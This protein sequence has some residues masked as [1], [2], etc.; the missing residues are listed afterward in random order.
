VIEIVTTEDGSNTLF[1]PELR[2]HYHSI[3]GAIQES[4]FIFINRGLDFSNANPVRIFEVGFGT[5]LNVLLSGIYAH[6]HNR[7]IF[8][9]SIEKYP[10]SEDIIH[11]LNYRDLV[12]NEDRELYEL[13]H[14]CKWNLPEKVSKN[15]TLLKIN[16]DF[17]TDEVSGNFDLVY[18]DAFGPDKQ[19]EMWTD[20][21]FKKISG[22]TVSNGILITYSVK[23]KVQR[24]LQKNGFNVSLLP[25]PPGKRQI[26]RAVKI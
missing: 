17:L 22:I 2:E 12:K 7:E 25:G 26:L 11:L 14:S 18:F 1:V 13:I 23:G 9:T 3:H 21:V 10:L 15:L 6:T 4:N 5:G 24:A 19:P 8:Y 20:H 16:G